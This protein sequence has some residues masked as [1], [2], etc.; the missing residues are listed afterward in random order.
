MYKHEQHHGGG[1]PYDFP[2]FG[3]RGAFSACQLRG[4]Y[5]GVSNAC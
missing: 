3:G 4:Q 5:P 1:G 2:L